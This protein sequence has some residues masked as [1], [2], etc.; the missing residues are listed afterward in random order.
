MDKPIRKDFM[1]ML[2]N[3]TKQIY[4]ISIVLIQVTKSNFPTTATSKEVSPNDSNNERQLEI[5]IMAAQTGNTY[6]FG[7]MI[8]SVEIPTAILGFSA[9]SSSNKVFPFKAAILLFPVVGRVCNHLGPLSL[10]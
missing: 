2:T 7:T 8:D 1:V 9:M 4:R 6:I 5:A 10:N 3:M